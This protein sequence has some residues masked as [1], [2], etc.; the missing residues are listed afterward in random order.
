MT[1]YPDAGHDAWTRAYATE[2]LYSWL[3]EHRR[4]RE[5]H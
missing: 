1:V 5:A 3:L 4:Y 2:E